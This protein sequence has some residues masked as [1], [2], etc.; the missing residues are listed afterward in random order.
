M[1][2]FRDPDETKISSVEKGFVTGVVSSAVRRGLGVGD[3]GERG[4]EG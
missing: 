3:R 1:Q 2:K 4:K